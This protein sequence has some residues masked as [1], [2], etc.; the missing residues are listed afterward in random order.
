VQARDYSTLAF[1]FFAKSDSEH[2]FN[3][4]YETKDAIDGLVAKAYLCGL[5][6]TK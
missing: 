1:A 5:N 2:G 4:S 3:I 6:L